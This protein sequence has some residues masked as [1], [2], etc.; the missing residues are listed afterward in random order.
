MEERAAWWE[1]HMNKGL[2]EATALCSGNKEK[3]IADLATSFFFLLKEDW[4]FFLY[5]LKKKL[6][7]LLISQKDH[8]FP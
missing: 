4:G 1:N 5:F 6:N 7:T 3:K 2:G 8:Y